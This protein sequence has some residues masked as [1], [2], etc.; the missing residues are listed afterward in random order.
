M[1][2][3][4]TEGPPKNLPGTPLRSGSIRAKYLGN[5]KEST[6]GPF[7]ASCEAKTSHPQTAIDG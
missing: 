4:P 7:A 2:P 3:L 5:P 1:V 6:D